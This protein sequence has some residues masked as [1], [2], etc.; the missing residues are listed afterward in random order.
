MGLKLSKENST[1]EKWNL[2]YDLLCEYKISNGNCRVTKSFDKELHTWT[3]SQ[4]RAKRINTITPEKI[5]KLEEI[6]FEWELTF[7]S[8]KKN[9]L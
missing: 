6:E 4:R 1:E 2:F 8:K 3:A 5:L 9:V 7:E